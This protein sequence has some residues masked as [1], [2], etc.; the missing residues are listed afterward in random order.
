[1]I[2]YFKYLGYSGIINPSRETLE[3]TSILPL[4]APEGYP[5]RRDTREKVLKE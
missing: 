5:L 1:M 2:N 4:D 3:N